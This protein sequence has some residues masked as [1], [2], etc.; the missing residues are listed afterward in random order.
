MFILYLDP[1]RFQDRVQERGL[2]SH[3]IA[4]LLSRKKVQRNTLSFTSSSANLACPLSWISEAQDWAAQS[5]WMTSKLE[6]GPQKKAGAG[7]RQL[8]SAMLGRRKWVIALLLPSGRNWKRILLLSFKSR[9]F[10][11]LCPPISCFSL[12]DLEL[13]CLFPALL[14]PCR[15]YLYFGML[16]AFFLFFFFVPS[17]GQFSLPSWQGLSL[18][19]LP[20]L[21][22]L[23]FLPSCSAA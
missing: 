23:F 10:Q 14:H 19:N 12:P 8:A 18:E 2:G 21:W 6:Q 9:E 15:L 11:V 13:F 4:A 22:Q 7:C 16:F 3:A 20:R 5:W 1:T 17:N